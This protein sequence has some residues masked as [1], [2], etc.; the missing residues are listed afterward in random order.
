M[1]LSNLQIQKGQPTVEKTYVLKPTVRFS[2]SDKVDTT[3]IQ[4]NMKELYDLF[5]ES[6]AATTA[7]TV[8]PKVSSVSENTTISRG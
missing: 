7:T 2:E 1:P 4:T 8:A 3:P 5:C 6:T